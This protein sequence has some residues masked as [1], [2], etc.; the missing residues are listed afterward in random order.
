MMS[1]LLVAAILWMGL[2]LP[3]WS[4]TVEERLTAGLQDQGY[5][6]LE[7]GYTF[8]GR[9]RI[10]A[11]SDEIHREIVVNPGTGEIL[12]D[13]AIYLSDIARSA[14]SGAD[15]T[16]GSDSS[17]DHT[18]SLPASTVGK[19]R[20]A[21]KTAA[22]PDISTVSPGLATLGVAGGADPILDTTL[23]PMG[24]DAP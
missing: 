3:G 15:L 16:G 5:T 22:S 6:I 18:A 9:L 24:P 23:L 20:G 8:L 7:K 1:K 13:Y 12:R 14:P 2:A 19:S 21:G 17:A 4:M 10:V 11:E